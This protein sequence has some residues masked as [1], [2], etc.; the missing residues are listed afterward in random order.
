MDT[1]RGRHQETIGNQSPPG[2]PGG[3]AGNRITLSTRILPQPAPGSP[4]LQRTQLVGSDPHPFGKAWTPRCVPTRRS[5]SQ[6][7]ADVSDRPAQDA[8]DPA[9]VP[10]LSVDIDQQRWALKPEGLLQ[11]PTDTDRH[12]RRRRLFRNSRRRSPT[13]TL[14]AQATPTYRRFSAE[15]ACCL[16]SAC[17]DQQMQQPAGE[18]I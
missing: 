12:Q 17:V 1:G 11:F 6:A 7:P 5:P 4:T 2:G 13:G 3:L 16:L 15:T 18:L 8:P 10:S 9:A 14:G